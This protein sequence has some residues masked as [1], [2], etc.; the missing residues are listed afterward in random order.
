VSFYE[1]DD[2]AGVLLGTAFEKTGEYQCLDHETLKSFTPELVRSAGRSFIENAWGSYVLMLVERDLGAIRILRGPMGYLPC[3]HSDFS[4]VRVFYSD[5][6]DFAALGLVRLSVNWDSLRAQASQQ[7]HLTRET[8]INEIT[9]V[10]SGECIEMRRG[11]WSRQAY[12][13]PCTIAKSRIVENFEEASASL[14]SLTRACVGARASRYDSIL[15]TLSGGID[16]S[17]VLGCLAQAPS[18]PRITCLNKYSSLADERRFARSMARKWNVEL[19]ERQRDENVD[20]AIFRRC[21]LT[22]RPVL[23]FSA[24]DTS[25]VTA[26]LGREVQAQA[27]FNGE[28]GDNVFGSRLGSEVFAECASRHGFG[29]RLAEAA[30]DV[31]HLGRVSI[32]NVLRQGMRV[33]RATRRARR[34]SATLFAH[35]PKHH[36]SDSLL[37]SDEAFAAHR[38]CADRFVHPWFEE[39]EGVPQGKFLLIYGLLVTTSSAYHAP[40]PSCDDLVVE[41]PLMS[42]PIVEHALRTASDLNVRAG[43]DRAVARHAFAQDLSPLVLNRRGKAGPA[44]WIKEVVA[45][46]VPF[47]RDVLLDGMLVKERIL[48]A[49]KIESLLARD[50]GRS[51]IHISQI[52]V[53]LYIECWLRRLLAAQ[54]RAAA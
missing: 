24:C 7:D 43:Q 23:N 52:F 41:S 30:L 49:R 29:G 2:H 39:I 5:V 10:L 27:L 48:D 14:R 16:S 40:F 17:I 32:W 9:E 51:T 37:I 50:I 6:Q 20:L 31:A 35:D 33:Y 18:R 54:S 13:H 3:F 38:K 36:R 25:R 45:R 44:P 53:Q 8:G 21:A 15:H 26:E 22:A 11:V 19:I 1:L 12:W 47:L 4:G 46:N 42:Q 34:W 28:L